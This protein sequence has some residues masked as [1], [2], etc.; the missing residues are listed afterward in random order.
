MAPSTIEACE[1]WS[2]KM[3]SP[4]RMMAEMKP[5]FAL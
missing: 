2:Q 4:A 1:Y 5:T 3:W